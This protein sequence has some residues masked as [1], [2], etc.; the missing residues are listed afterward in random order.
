MPRHP[1]TRHVHVIR[2]APGTIFLIALALAGTFLLIE[3][4]AKVQTVIV[5]FLM[6]YAL[7]Q[8]GLPQQ[9]QDLVTQLAN[10]L[11]QSIPALLLL[12]FRVGSIMFYGLMTVVISF[13]WLLAR[14]RVNALAIY[15]V[16]PAKRD[17][18]AEIIDQIGARVGAWVC[19]KRSDLHR[20]SCAR[21]AFCRG[22][23]GLGGRDRVDPDHWPDTR[24]DPRLDHR[25]R[26]LAA[27]SPFRAHTLPGYPAIRDP[28][29]GA[30]RD[31]PGSGSSP[32]AYGPAH[33]RSAYGHSGGDSRRPPR[34]GPRSPGSACSETLRATRR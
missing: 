28:Y 3:F 19:D 13:Y 12:P 15:A 8:L 1:V 16:P 21:D 10:N 14:K 17:E 34:L 31:E 30:Q 18:V 26:E 4:L 20:F 24:R 33:G 5:I 6:Y 23:I 7:T 22:L 32:A 2:I 25:F 11:T 27:A 9:L 29:P